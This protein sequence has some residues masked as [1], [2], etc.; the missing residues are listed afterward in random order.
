MFK[1]DKLALYFIIAF[2][3]FQCWYASILPIGAE[4]A[5]VFFK[6]TGKGWFSQSHPGIGALG[7]YF[8]SSFSDDIFVLRLPSVIMMSFAAAF[9]FK[10]AHILG[11]RMSGMAALLIFLF[12]PSVNMAYV[13]ATPAASFILFSAIAFFFW[14]KVFETD[15]INYYIGAGATSGFLI[16]SHSAGFF[17]FAF[18]VLYMLIFNRATLVSRKFLFACIFFVICPAALFIAGISGINIAPGNVPF[19]FTESKPMLLLFALLGTPAII[20][21]LTGLIC[22]RLKTDGFNFLQISFIGA[23]VFFVILTFVSNIDIRYSPAFFI[24]CF[25]LAGGYFARKG[26]KVFIGLIMAVSVALT[27][28]IKVADYKNYYLPSGLRTSS[29]YEAINI[30]VSKI[31]GTSGALF[32]GSMPEA[33]LYSYYTKLSDDG[34]VSG[35]IMINMTRP[36][37]GTP[38]PSKH[39]EPC[40]PNLCSQNKGVFVAETNEIDPKTIFAIADY[41]GI[42]RHTKPKDGTKSFYIYT[43]ER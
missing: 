3:S 12:T 30:P 36:S 2:A 14:L 37:T 33:S 7:V 35:D 39:P 29:L 31:L 43:V 8:V 15:K 21:S 13:S 1:N 40:L 17:L 28:Y 19:L 26:D 25:I 34:I 20:Y 24:P 41:Y 18:A 16:M 23:A 5:Y 42:S 10:S 9:V 4:E 11:G 32:A 22:N 27:V 38:K 6:G